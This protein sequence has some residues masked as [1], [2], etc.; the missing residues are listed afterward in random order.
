MP[1]ETPRQIKSY[2]ERLKADRSTWESL[3]QEVAEHGLARRTTFTAKTT[4]QGEGKQTKNIFDNTMMV[5]NDLLA[6][7]LHNLLPSP[8]LRW[9]HLEPEDAILKEDDEALEWFHAAEE[10]MAQEIQ[11]HTAYFHPEIHEVYNDI[12]AFGNGAFSTLRVPGEGLFFQA[13]PLAETYIDVGADSRIQSVFRFMT[14]NALQFTNR[15]GEGKSEKMDRA[16]ADGKFTQE[17]DILQCIIPNELFDSRVIFGKRSQRFKS[18][19][20]SYSDAEELEETFFSENP[21]TFARWNKDPGEL[22]ARGPGVQ[23]LSNARMLSEMSKTSLQGAQKAVSPPLMV[24]DNGLITQLDM[25]PDGLTVYRAGTVDPVRELYTRPGQN[26]DLGV[27]MLQNYQ[28]QVRAAYHFELLQLIQDPRMSATQVIELSSRVQQILGP[29]VGRLQSELLQPVLERVYTILRKMGKFPQ[30]P[31]QLSGQPFR[32]NFVSPIQRAQRATE[33]QALLAALNSV[34]QVAQLEPTAL[35]SLDSD[36]IARFMFDAYGV[37]PHLLRS[38][39]FVAQ[40]REARA[41]QLEQQE[42]INQAQQLAGAAAPVM[43]ALPGLAQMGEG[44]PEATG[45]PQ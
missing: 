42:Q 11:R 7:G 9:F 18:L 26:P 29:L 44:A 16:M 1:L 12:A 13:M 20:L 14:W 27:Q 23:A 28:T 22:Y 30:I 4:P 35:D 38:E 25:S 41:A 5:S 3:W 8:S 36:Q 19:F 17:I 33:G 21:I 32:I 6:S 15:F 43:Q 39:E 40:M 45:G 10:I 37:P 34:I 31:E 2:F 24:P